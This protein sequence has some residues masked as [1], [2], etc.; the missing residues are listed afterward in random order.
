[1]KN[2]YFIE[3]R[4]KTLIFLKKMG[5]RHFFRA[6][7]QRA[8]QVL[9]MVLRPPT[10]Q[11][12]TR[13]LTKFWPRHIAMSEKKMRALPRTGGATPMEQKKNRERYREGRGW[14]M[15]PPWSEQKK[16]ASAT[17]GGG[18]GGTPME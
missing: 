3:K 11:K 10:P 1:M 8:D 2:T 12:K 18:E 9:K 14:G 7:L 15:A 16:I 4:E 17:A 6:K 13:V 5:T